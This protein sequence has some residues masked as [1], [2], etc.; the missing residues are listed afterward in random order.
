M[1]SNNIT[2]NLLI[3]IGFGILFYVLLTAIQVHLRNPVLPGATIAISMI[4]PVLAGILFGRYS[5]ALVGLAGTTVA[6]FVSSG[7]EFTLLSIIPHT[8]MG[9]LAGALTESRNPVT[10]SLS[11]LIGYILNIMFFIIAKITPVST[12][13]NPQFYTGIGFEIIALLF[14]INILRLM[15]EEMLFNFSYKRNRW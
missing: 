7:S 8:I 10:A 6:V 3:R 5:G 12:F 14:A 1:R 13:S 4:V 2:N 11:L 9:Y 15:Y